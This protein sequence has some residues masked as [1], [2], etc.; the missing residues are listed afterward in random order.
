MAK[1]SPQVCYANAVSNLGMGAC[2]IRCKQLALHDVQ[3]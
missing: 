3:L 1:F 2:T